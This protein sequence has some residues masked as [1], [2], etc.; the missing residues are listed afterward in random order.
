MGCYTTQERGVKTLGRHSPLRVSSP[1]RQN[2]TRPHHLVRSYGSV[3]KKTKKHGDLPA[4][5][6]HYSPDRHE[7]AA[8]PNPRQDRFQYVVLLLDFALRGQ[9]TNSNSRKES[10]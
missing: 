9:Q 5:T 6:G 4:V 7:R 3:P 1:S 10:T 8:L 2:R